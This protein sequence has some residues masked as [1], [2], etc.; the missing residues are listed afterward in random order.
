MTSHIKLT[1]DHDENKLNKS[2]NSKSSSASNSRRQSVDKKMDLCCDSDEEFDPQELVKIAKPPLSNFVWPPPIDEPKVPIA[3]PLYTPVPETLHVTVKPCTYRPL[4]QRQPRVLTQNVSK[5][6]QQ[7]VDFECLNVDCNITATTTSTSNASSESEYK[8][9][10][11]QNNHYANMFEQTKEVDDEVENI[12]KIVIDLRKSPPPIE[13]PKNIKINEFVEPEVG[14]KA[15][16]FERVF[17]NRKEK[18]MTMSS[19]ETS[20]KKQ[21]M[22]KKEVKISEECPETIPDGEDGEENDVED[23]IKG[24]HVGPYDGTYYQLAPSNIPQPT[25]K[26]YQSGL[27][28]ALIYS[29]EKPIQMRNMPATPEPKFPQMDNFERAVKEVENCPPPAPKQVIKEKPI[30]DVKTTPE[31]RD[32]PY[33][34][35]EVRSGNTLFSAMVRTASPRPIEFVKSN[36]IEEVQLPDDIDAYFPPPISMQPNEPYP[37]INSYR[38]KS[39]FVAALTTISDRPF[40]PFGR[41]IMSQL[42]L[43]LPQTR[44]KVTFSNALHTAPDASFDTSTLEYEFDENNEISPV[45]YTA[46]VYERCVAETNEMEQEGLCYG[47]VTPMSRNFLPTIQPWSVASEVV[48]ENNY[49]DTTSNESMECCVTDSRRASEACACVCEPVCCKKNIADLLRDPKKEQEEEFDPEKPNENAPYPKAL[50]QSQFEG[51]QVKVTNKMTSGLHKPDEIPDYQRKWY[52]LPTQNP[53]HTPEPEE[54]KENVPIAFKEWSYHEEEDEE[55]V[56]AKPPIPPT[57]HRGSVSEKV[58]KLEDEVVKFPSRRSQQFEGFFPTKSSREKGPIDVFLEKEAEEEKSDAIF[59]ISNAVIVDSFPTKGVRKNSVLDLPQK[60]KAQ[61]EHIKSLN[62][63]LIMQQQK[64]QTKAKVRQQREL[65]NMQRNYEKIV[66]ETIREEIEQNEELSSYEQEQ[67]YK[68]QL[69]F[70]KEQRQKEFE[71]KQQQA[72]E[73]EY[74]R[75]LEEHK[76]HEIKMKEKREREYQS[77]LQRDLEFQKQRESQEEMARLNQEARDRV[78][79]KQQEEVEREILRQQEQE[80]RD[81][82]ER[83]TRRQLEIIRKE[84]RDRELA[85]IEEELRQKRE[86]E[87][88]KLE[89]EIRAK[90]EQK[91]REEQEAERRKHQDRKDREDAEKEAQRLEKEAIDAQKQRER[92]LQTEL[93]MRQ[94]QEADRKQREETELFDLEEERKRN[95]ELAKKAKAYQSSTY[96]QSTVWPPSTSSTPAPNAARQIPVI[97][98]EYDMEYELNPSK[99]HFEPLDE[100]QKRFMAGIRPPS[101][102][103][104]PPTDEKPFPS[105]PY[106]QQHLAFHEAHP[107]HEGLFDPRSA[108]PAVKNRSRSPAFGPPPNPLRPFVN[109]QRDP[110]LDESGIYLCGERLLSPVWYDK[111]HK[112]VPHAVCKRIP[113][114]GRSS[115]GTKPPPTPPPMPPMPRTTKKICFAPDEKEAKATVS[116]MPPKGIVA[117]QVRRL[118]SDFSSSVFSLRSSSLPQAENHQKET[119]SPVVRHDNSQIKQDLRTLTQNSNNFHINHPT[120]NQ[121]H[122]QHH[123]LAALTSSSTSAQTFQNFSQ[124]SHKTFVSDERKNS[125]DNVRVST[126][127]VGQPGALAK[128]GRTFTT[129]GPNRGQ[130]ILTQPATGRV[131]ICGACANQIRYT[132]NLLVV[133]IY[134]DVFLYFFNFKNIF[135]IFFKTN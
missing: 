68:R 82:E 31:H 100:D 71:L 77:Q 120:N 52:N 64:M 6:E 103:Y 15:E 26:G 5:I 23:E 53:L 105:I 25:P 50:H 99:F 88:Q 18:W 91:M 44:Q 63:E 10:Q 115:G 67:E 60:Q 114:H 122:H 47:R 79:R 128:H 65:E 72:R 76:M 117:S 12:N 70:E 57:E 81:A 20:S 101:T 86:E 92:E 108:S 43:D 30:F 104:S 49:K 113:V 45:E 1:K 11:T 2:C 14:Y 89:E 27:Q 58:Q 111:Q 59:P 22:V 69:E 83:E 126:G 130:G 119:S 135:A 106:Y 19:C 40:T 132:K 123:N 51:M 129:S 24:L 96:Q 112:K 110:E 54:L 34:E 97:R 48:P 127:S 74:Q 46:K 39:P 87:L 37:S 38:T 107:D 28:K 116:E 4:Q 7:E 93:K 85:K 118:S 17:S 98:T 94:K 3:A 95:E 29:S 33:S 32:F 16:T 13:L 131:P 102:C 21:K 42:S 56:A 80:R 55:M 35:Q 9:Y 66:H 90:R 61:F 84:E 36:V 134:F 133:C 109:K 41:E 124:N 125:V 75:Q 121:H 73:Q 62:H 8:M 78:M